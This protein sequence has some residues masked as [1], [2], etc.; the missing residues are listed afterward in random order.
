[1]KKE[2]DEFCELVMGTG[3]AKMIGVFVRK[4]ESQED[5]KKQ[6]PENSTGERNRQINLTARERKRALNDVHSSVSHPP[7]FTCSFTAQF[8]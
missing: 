4:I 5:E 8:D 6:K 1:M 2:I 7:R 3:G